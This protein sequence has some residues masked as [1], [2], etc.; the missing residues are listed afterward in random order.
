MEQPLKITYRNIEPTP[1]IEAKI[2]ERA[3]KLDR[4]YD[5]I[6]G[7]HV[8]IEVPHH[9]QH[10][11][12]LYHVH[13]DLAVKN[14]ELQVG[15]DPAQHHAHED[16]YVA[17]RDAFDAARRRLQDHARRQRGDLK[18]S[19]RPARARVVRLFPDEGYGFLETPDQREI[20]FHR[21]SVLNDGFARLVV[22][23]EVRFAEEMGAQGPQASTVTCV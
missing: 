18:T 22:G 17:I 8:T 4:Y 20:Y 1:A 7:C 5:G 13:I 2:R 15:R 3:D 19:E 10:S 16:L 11:G 14:G 12:A 23:S 6:I 9:H 21:N